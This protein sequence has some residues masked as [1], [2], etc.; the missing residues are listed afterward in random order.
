MA[1]VPA[2]CTQSSS[3]PLCPTSG[4]LTATS[5][6]GVDAA[7]FR[8]VDAR[9]GVTW[10][11]KIRDNGAPIDNAFV[12]SQAEAAQSGTNHRSGLSYTCTSPCRWDANGDKQLWV[13][14]RAVVRGRPRDLVALLK[15]E[16]LLEATPETAIVAGGIKSNNHGNKIM[17]YG[18]GSQIVVRCNL[19]SSNCVLAEPGQIQPPPVRVSSP[20]LMTPTQL[21]RF[22][23]RAITDGTY[24]AGCPDGNLAGAVVWVENCSTTQSGNSVI[25][26]PCNPLPPP[27]P[28]GGGTPLPS[29]CVNQY[30]RPG[31]L[32]WH[33][34]KMSMS[35][36]WTFRGMLYAVNNSDGTCP[37]SAPAAGDGNCSGNG[38]GSNMVMA[39][40]GGFGVWGAI[41]IDG[42]GCLYIGSDGIQV[43]FD[44]NVF[45][46]V[47]SYGTV[48]LVQNTW[49]ELPPR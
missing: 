9:S 20:P 15:L 34:G 49:R 28:G 36:G 30:N 43:Y 13:Q 5:A 47:A 31:I 41:A 1:T 10:M 22:K 12:S 23:Q 48:G 39:M 40:T 8:N 16:H 25:S 46:A 7:T 26:Q 29:T 3:D 42:G 14:A 45:G 35:G 37:A 6:A 38:N 21:A 27:S 11:T 18:H 24:F 4:M 44:P 2:S 33:C 17:L 19:S 32:I